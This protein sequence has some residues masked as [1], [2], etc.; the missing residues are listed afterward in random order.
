MCAA[1][2]LEH[3][4]LHCFRNFKFRFPSVDEQE[5]DFKAPLRLYAAGSHTS[6]GAIF[7]MLKIESKLYPQI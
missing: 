5:S 6:H 3:G 7:L 1:Q 2:L 4:S